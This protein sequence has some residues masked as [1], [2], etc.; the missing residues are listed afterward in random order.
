MKLSGREIKAMPLEEVIKMLEKEYE[1]AK[2]LSYVRDPMAYA[3]HKVWRKV[4]ERVR[5]NDHKEEKEETA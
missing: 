1:H 4:D 2:T 3:L 5:K